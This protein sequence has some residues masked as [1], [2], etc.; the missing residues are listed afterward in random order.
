MLP[1]IEVYVEYRIK[2]GQDC[3]PRWR[4]LR[5]RVRQVDSEGWNYGRDLV[6]PVG[7]S[8]DACIAEC[9]KALGGLALEVRFV[10]QDEIGMTP[11]TYRNGRITKVA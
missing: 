11:R 7:H 2:S 3:A 10:F 6:R 4:A 5:A 9:L 8:I 1:L